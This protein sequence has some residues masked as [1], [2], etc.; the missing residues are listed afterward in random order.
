MNQ[1]TDKTAKRITSFTFDQLDTAIK[2]LKRSPKMCDTIAAIGKFDDWEVRS[3]VMSKSNRSI[4]DQIGV[5]QKRV[6]EN[7]LTDNAGLGIG[8]GAFQLTPLGKQAAIELD[9]PGFDG[10]KI[11]EE[12]KATLQELQTASKQVQRSNPMTDIMAQFAAS[13]GAPLEVSLDGKV[14]RTL[15]AMRDRK[16]IDFG[17]LSD[18]AESLKIFLTEYGRQVGK[19]IDGID[20]TPVCE[21]PD[22]HGHFQS[23]FAEEK[24]A[25]A[26]SVSASVCQTES[27]ERS[28]QDNASHDTSATSQSHDGPETRNEQAA[29]ARYTRMP[30]FDQGTKQAWVDNDEGGAI[31]YTSIED[32]DPNTEDRPPHDYIDAHNAL[33][34]GL[35]HANLNENKLYPIEI[36]SEEHMLARGLILDG[37]AKVRSS[38]T[39][40]QFDTF[41]PVGL[42]MREYFR[43]FE[44]FE[45]PD[46]YKRKAMF[47]DNPIP[48]ERRPVPQKQKPQ[49]SL[50]GDSP[51][52][53]NTAPASGGLEGFPLSGS[54]R[55]SADAISK[56][57]S[58]QTALSLLLNARFFELKKGTLKATVEVAL[59]QVDLVEQV[60]S[61][62]VRPGIDGEEAEFFEPFLVLTHRGLELALLAGLGEQRSPA[63][64]WSLYEAN[65]LLMKPNPQHVEVL[66]RDIHDSYYD[67]LA[68][69]T[70]AGEDFPNES[71]D[72]R[73]NTNIAIAIDAWC[74]VGAVKKA[75]D[76][77]G[78]K[79]LTLVGLA[80][81]EAIM[82]GESS[83][84]P[85]D[86]VVDGDRGHQSEVS[87][88]SAP[89]L[90]VKCQITDAPQHCPVPSGEDELADE[91]ED[92]ANLRKGVRE[93]QQM[94]RMQDFA[95][96]LRQPDPEK[97]IHI[98]QIAKLR[99]FAASDELGHLAARIELYTEEWLDKDGEDVACQ[100]ALL[101][102]DV[103]KRIATF[104]ERMRW[105]IADAHDITRPLPKELDR[106]DS[107]DR[108][109]MALRDAAK[110]ALEKAPKAERDPLAKTETTNASGKRIVADLKR[111]QQPAIFPKD[112]PSHQA[113][114]DMIEDGVI[115]SGPV[116][117]KPDKVMVWARRELKSQ[118]DKWFR[119]RHLDRK[120][121]DNGPLN[122]AWRCGDSGPVGW[123]LPDIDPNSIRDE[124]A[125]DAVY[126]F[127]HW[128]QGLLEEIA[129]EESQGRLFQT[130]QGSDEHY[131]LWDALISTGPGALAI[132]KPSDKPQA[133]YLFIGKAGGE[134]IT[135][136]QKAH[137]DAMKALEEK[138]EKPITYASPSPEAK[139][140]KQDQGSTEDPSQIELSTTVEKPVE[141][142]TEESP[143]PCD[144]RVVCDWC[145]SAYNTETVQGMPAVRY[146][147]GRKVIE[148]AD[149]KT[150]ITVDSDDAF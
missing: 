13:H 43:Y 110:E 97:A 101:L 130:K 26:D 56:S 37:R 132:A 147:E 133:P 58:M 134:L 82:S 120:R 119:V 45:L 83:D 149:C 22:E 136:A 111:T 67:V 33:Y 57:T 19:L 108:V 15:M 62:D 138:P 61:L 122:K 81:H 10:P 77:T 92:I 51:T 41:K 109:L 4:L 47:E 78:N 44:S 141:N 64:W 112:G 48:Q 8:A 32:G 28:E 95:K 38:T 73:F 86:G 150:E 140:P 145:G 53:P 121:D 107:K 11:Y 104:D 36:G 80:L 127:W 100:L 87:A 3:F 142:S 105:L 75:S 55:Y 12:E 49:L 125:Q 16:L 91:D 14:R 27:D 74:R 35:K 146:E 63:D 72:P 60:I 117:G 89:V 94:K 93:Y 50:I 59:L 84:V 98:R 115:E 31:R 106:H 39:P 131:A 79:S 25:A 137:E 5:L 2:K 52:A 23:H 17:E 99:E 24:K 126:L 144:G 68:L 129:R 113:I 65:S 123:F 7:I 114:K 102:R 90:D 42:V 96:R 1:A 46:E 124:D 30:D 66:L 40:A 128:R 34:Q 69:R 20:F 29:D 21:I 6:G 71:Q 54:T 9:L 70:V 88:N 139:A 18:D 103:G 76:G 118:N 85:T 116:D 143:M 135:A 148:C